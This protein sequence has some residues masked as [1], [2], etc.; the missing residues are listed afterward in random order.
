MTDEIIIVKSN[1]HES[2]ITNT[3]MTSFVSTSSA[4]S[5]SLP[6]SLSTEQPPINSKN[7][8]N[9]VVQQLPLHEHETHD[10]DENIIKTQN[11]IS[12]KDDVEA[13]ISNSN[14]NSIKNNQKLLIDT[15]H[16]LF[17]PLQQQQKQQQQQLTRSNLEN[18]NA[19]ESV[20]NNCIKQD[21]SRNTDNLTENQIF[22]YEK[23]LS[24]RTKFKNTDHSKTIDQ[25]RCKKLIN[26]SKKSKS[27]S[28]LDEKGF[29]N[30]TLTASHECW[31]NFTNINNQITGEFCYCY[32]K[33]L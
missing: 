11:N 32:S 6:R 31:H 28:C 29:D 7:N 24:S 26:L 18:L 33:R 14:N 2:S 5:S 8:S 22:P 27:D 10:A 13:A 30:R 15:S 16:Q 21:L 1:L 12:N 23:C 17:L 25:T 20:N 4:S 19:Y 3:N 9:N